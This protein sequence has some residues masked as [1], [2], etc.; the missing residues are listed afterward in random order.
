MGYGT[1]T[2]RGIKTTSSVCY[3]F[4]NNKLGL[5]EN[6]FANQQKLFKLLCLSLL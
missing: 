5:F 3:L 4:I 2:A 6:I 1:R